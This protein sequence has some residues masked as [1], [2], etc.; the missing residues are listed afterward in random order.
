MEIKKGTTRVVI[1]TSKY[2]FKFPAIYSWRLFLHGLLANMQET[3]FWCQL[4]SYK[5][6]PVLF[7]LPL[8]FLVVMPRAT[9]F[10]NKN[11][12]YFCYETF[13][14]ELGWIIPV[15]NK[16]DSFGFINGQIVAIDYGS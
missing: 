2:A 10:T 6:C 3:D 11:F 12:E 5:L 8:G 13:V 1:L 7:S 15:E 9:V 14:N 4:K 16:R